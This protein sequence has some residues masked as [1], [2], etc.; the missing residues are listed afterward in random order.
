LDANRFDALARSLEDGF[1]RRVALGGALGAGFASLLSP[2]GAGE[3]DAK[4]R[5]KK[6]K[7]CKG[8]KKKCGKKCILKTEC[9]GGCGQDEECCDGTC[10]NVQTDAEHCGDCDIAC[11]TGE[12]CL[13]GECL[14]GIGTC[15]VGDDFC[16]NVQ[17]VCNDNQTCQCLQSFDGQTRCGSFPPGGFECGQCINDGECDEFGPGAFC[18]RSTGNGGCIC[19]IGLGF[20]IIPCTFQ[21]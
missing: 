16:T 17:D 12:F 19:T 8:G 6:K 14:V 20:C 1:P 2:F 10:F 15:D 21:V 4:K 9:C 18:A 7:K 11:G 3:A 5:K 13:D